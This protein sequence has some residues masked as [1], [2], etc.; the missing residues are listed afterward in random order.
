MRLPPDLIKTLFQLHLEG[1]KVE[2]GEREKQGFSGFEIKSGYCYSPQTC[3]TAILLCWEIPDLNKSPL[4]KVEESL[5]PW[6]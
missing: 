6:V 1:G 3:G 5:K 4:L 2:V